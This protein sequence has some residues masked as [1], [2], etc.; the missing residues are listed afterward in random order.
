[1]RCS[2]DK[3]ENLARHCCFPQGSVVVKMTCGQCGSKLG[4]AWAHCLVMLAVTGVGAVMLEAR[5]QLF[6]RGPASLGGRVQS[7][8][9]ASWRWSATKRGG[10]GRLRVQGARQGERKSGVQSSSR[11]PPAPPAPDSHVSAATQKRR[12]SSTKLERRRRG[13]WGLLGG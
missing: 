6:F 12:R 5:F 2:Y 9:S 8:S 11:S 13:L 4:E 1:M 7:R 3:T 10:S